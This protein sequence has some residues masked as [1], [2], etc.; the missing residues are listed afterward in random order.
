MIHFKA[1]TNL[2]PAFCS[3]YYHCTKS[4]SKIRDSKEFLTFIQNKEFDRNFKMQMSDKLWLQLQ[5][6]YLSN[7][8]KTIIIA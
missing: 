5:K 2:A 6:Q 7:V 1:L 4:L 3:E 8:S